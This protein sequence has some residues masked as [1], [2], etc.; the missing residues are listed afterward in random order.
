MPSPKPDTLPCD[1]PG[2]LIIATRK[3]LER[4]PRSRHQLA[5]DLGVPF[6]W[7]NVFIQGAI[8]APSV[9]RVQYIYEKLSGQKVIY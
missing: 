4:D 8:E 7:L 3:L 1:K 2:S 9:N 6:Y 5:L